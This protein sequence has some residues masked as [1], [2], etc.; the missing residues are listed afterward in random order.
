MC[1]ALRDLK[2]VLRRTQSKTG[3]ASEACQM[4][5]ESPSPSKLFMDFEGLKLEY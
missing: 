2:L 3:T 4:T 5:A 1:A